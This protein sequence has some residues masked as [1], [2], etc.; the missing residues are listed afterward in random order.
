MSENGR[1]DVVSEEAEVVAERVGSHAEISE[2]FFGTA[3]PEKLR[4]EMDRIVGEAEAVSERRE[5]GRTSQPP[6]KRE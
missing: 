3:T 4:I 6:Y 2:E 5:K 1:S